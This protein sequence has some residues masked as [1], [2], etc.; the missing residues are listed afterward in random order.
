MVKVK[1][2]I[3]GNFCTPNDPPEIAYALMLYIEEAVVA[4]GLVVFEKN[5]LVK[6]IVHNV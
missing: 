3:S 4:E 5:T 2:T 6:S 1:E